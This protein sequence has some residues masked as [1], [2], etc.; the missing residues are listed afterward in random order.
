[1]I[2]TLVGRDRELCVVDD[3]VERVQEGPTSLVI[4]GEPGIGK[5]SLLEAAVESLCARD[6]RVLS[7]RAVEAEARLSFTAIADLLES[8]LDEVMATLRSVRRRALSVALLL[9]EPDAE[10]LDQRTI[11]AGLVDA[12]HQLASVRPL[13]VAI[14]D[15]QWLD[16]SSARALQFALRRVGSSRVGLLVTMRGDHVDVPLA[17][18]TVERLTLGPLSQAG[19]H[20]LLRDELG[21]NL[22][23]PELSRLGDATGGNPLFALEV[24][25]ELASSS[26][27]RTSADPLPVPRSFRDLLGERVRRLPAATR[28]VL[29]SAATAG[30]PTFDVLAAIHGA[31]TPARLEE[32]RRAGVI[33]LDGPRVRFAHPLLAAACYQDAPI[34][35]RRASHERLATAMSDPEER[36]R[37]LALARDSPNGPVA[38]AVADAAVYAAERGRTSAAG[39]L[40]ELAASLTPLTDVSAKRA[41]LLRAAELHRLAGER[42]RAGSLLDELLTDAI[43][44]ERSDVLLELARTRQGSVSSSIGLCEQALAATDDPA[45]VAD[46]L[47][48]LSFL[49]ILAG[50]LYSALAAARAGL[51]RAELVDDPDLLARTIGRV[52]S[53]EQFALEITPGLLERGVELERALPRPLG[54]PESPTLTLARRLSLLGHLGLARDVMLL[55]ERRAEALGDEGT[56]GQL[57]FYLTM[58]E[59]HAGRWTIGLEHCD[60]ALELAEQL[61]DA[62]FRGMVLYGRAAILG[63]LGRVDEARALAGE[64]SSIAEASEDATF[65]VWTASLLGFIELSLGNMT[66]ASEWLTPLP[67]KLLAQGW[68]EPADPWPETIEVL[69]ALNELAAAADLLETFEGLAGRLGA[70]H[71]LAMAARCRGLIEAAEGDTDGA[72]RSYDRALEYHGRSEHRF[73]LGRTLLAAGS[74]RR[75]ARQKKVARAVLQSA[76]EIFAELG[77]SLWLARTDQEMARIA[78][79][80]PAGSSLTRM[81]M[82]VLGLVV[83]GHSNKEIAR[84]LYVSVHTVEAHLTRI[85]RKLGV[86]SRGELIARSHRGVDEMKM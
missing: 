61:G 19:I 62:Q 21:L 6:C 74:T 9:E 49:R 67:G 80:A 10:P 25:R 40:L 76:R 13:V 23:R 72:L 36:A 83:R 37:H 78:G 64:V 51:E 68:N 71:G 48:Y 29:L 34:W 54:Y 79:R 82:Q 73:E 7:C 44:D 3:F 43:G 57:L 33:E 22:T 59:W 52:A 84:T 55:E 17:C 70:P 47:A 28:D 1:M 20:R 8:V 81:E 38:D 85:Y 60:V 69:V 50:D 65:P 5:T 41:R 31:S 77:A 75:R 4:E 35:K 2:D 32:A 45:R 56:R 63:R 30:R 66:T 86:R 27:G 18:G 39:E 24:G 16:T 14:D 42:V 11:G 58:V 15:V 26:D 53:A 12:L 46:V